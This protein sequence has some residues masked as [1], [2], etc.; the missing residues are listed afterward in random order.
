V[1]E[2]LGLNEPGDRSKQPTTPNVPTPEE[3]ARFEHIQ[4]LV[5]EIE[6]LAPSE[7]ERTPFRIILGA[8]IVAVIMGVLILDPGSL[9]DTLG[10]IAT[11]GVPTAIIAS[12]EL[13]YRRRKTRR[14]L[15]LERELE[16]LLPISQSSVSDR[17]G[18]VE[19]EQ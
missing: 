8:L 15:A 2:E 11:F 18:A 3:R 7:P 13:R 6:R 16:G 10:A 12:L 5:Q 1:N 14:R 9:A 17:L 4:T 19:P